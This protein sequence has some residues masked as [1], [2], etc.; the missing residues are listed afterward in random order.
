MNV[1][2]PALIGFVWKFLVTG[3]ANYPRL[4]HHPCHP[5]LDL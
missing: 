5:F 1:I 3:Y 4:H 2:I